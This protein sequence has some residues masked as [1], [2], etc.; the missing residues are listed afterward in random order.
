MGIKKQEFYEGA[1]LHRLVRSGQ[2]ARIQY[3][4][5]F[6]SLNDKLSILLKYTTK[7]RSPW[8]FTFTIDEQASL[9]SLSSKRETVIALVCGADGVAAFSYGDYLTIASPKMARSMSPVIEIMASITRYA[10][11]TES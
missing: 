7:G 3:E 9:K 5:P 6:F 2:I 8:G 4:A 11:L 10:G 1:A